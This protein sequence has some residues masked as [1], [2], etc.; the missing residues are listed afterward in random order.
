MGDPIYNFYKSVLHDLYSD[1]DIKT[2]GIS[3][4]MSVSDLKRMKAIMQGKYTN[5]KIQQFTGKCYGKS[6][7]EIKVVLNKDIKEV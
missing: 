3:Q 1:P 6:Y 5:I 2:M 4:E 7:I